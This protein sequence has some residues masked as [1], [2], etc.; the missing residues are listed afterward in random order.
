[1]TIFAVLLPLAGIE[2]VMLLEYLLWQP[3]DRAN[4]RRE[5]RDAA[6]LIDEQTALLSMQKE[7]EIGLKSSQVVAVAEARDL[8]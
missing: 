6:E 7:K 5:G 4:G 3:E 1:M 2:V 8:A